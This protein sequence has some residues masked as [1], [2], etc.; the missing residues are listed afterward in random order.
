MD[1]ARIRY[2]V[3]L[4][5]LTLSFQVLGRLDHLDRDGSPEQVAEL[6]ARIARRLA[7]MLER[8]GLAPDGD[9]DEVDPLATSQPWLAALASACGPRVA[10]L[11]LSD[12]R[13]PL[14]ARRLLADAEDEVSIAGA[15]LDEAQQR[16]CQRRDLQATPP[17]PPPPPSVD[18][19]FAAGGIF[20]FQPSFR[21]SGIT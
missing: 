15:S 1:A 20:F 17:C 12:P 14:E 19:F 8:R 9:P 13:L 2:L 3:T 4:G 6:A 11:T 10:R 5:L 21:W 7:R 18:H 16:A